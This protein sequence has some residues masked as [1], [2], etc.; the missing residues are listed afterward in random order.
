MTSISGASTDTQ[1]G[2]AKL[3]YDQLALKA[4]IA[5]PTFTG[6]VALG[7]SPTMTTP[8]ITGLPTGTGVASAATVSTLAARDASGNLTTVNFIEGY[9]T[10]N[11][12]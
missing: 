2:S 5:S 10:R 7:T 6:T 4:P 9:Q 1:Y 3:L 12:A 11:T 8:V